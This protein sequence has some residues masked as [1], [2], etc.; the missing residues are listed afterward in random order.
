[1]RVSSWEGYSNKDLI[2]Q[3]IRSNDVWFPGGGCN[4]GEGFRQSEGLRVYD[5]GVGV[6]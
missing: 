4:R 1:M 3:H 6:L 5:V 2:Q